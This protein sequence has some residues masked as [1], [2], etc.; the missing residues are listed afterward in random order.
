MTIHVHVVGD[1]VLVALDIELTKAE[2]TL[3]DSGK[4]EA[5]TGSGSRIRR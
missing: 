5:V 2:Q 1:F 3:L 4:T